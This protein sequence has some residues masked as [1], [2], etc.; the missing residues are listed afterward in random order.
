MKLHV[1]PLRQRYNVVMD[2]LNLVHDPDVWKASAAD[3]S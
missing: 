3:A 1:A 2:L